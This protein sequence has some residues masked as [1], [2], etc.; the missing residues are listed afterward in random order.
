MAT[1]PPVLGN[2]NG[3]RPNAPEAQPSGQVAAK[4][5]PNDAQQPY[6][7]N[8]M[9]LADKKPKIVEALRQ[10]VVDYR[11]EGI[12][13]RRHEIRRIR[14]ARMFYQGLQYAFYDTN[15]EMWVVPFTARNFDDKDQ[16]E[17][18][19]FMYVTNFY[20]GYALA[21]RR[22][23]PRLRTCARPRLPPT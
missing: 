10:M 1:I 17:Q 6:G 7:E 21:G 22:K 18:P 20:L 16:E 5:S 2:L 19:R 23:L 8:N 12:V 4:D 9:Y 3:Q 15:N 11:A 13:A 14:Q